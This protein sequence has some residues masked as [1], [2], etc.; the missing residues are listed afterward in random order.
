MIENISQRLVLLFTFF[1]AVVGV[2]AP[3]GITVLVVLA[4]LAGLL[5]WWRGR[6]PA[7][8]PGRP[9]LVTLGALALWALAASLWSFH[10]TG[11]MALVLRLAAVTAAGIGLM[12]ALAGLDGRTRR[13]VENAFLF[14]LALA[15]AAIAFG[16][17]YAKDTGLSLWSNFKSDPLTTLNN[18]AVTLSLLCWPAFALFRRKVSWTFAVVIVAAILAGFTALSS[19]AALL[20]PVAGCFGFVIIWFLG[21]PGAVFISIVTAIMILA[22]PQVISATRSLDMVS[23]AAESLVS[24][25]DH[26]LKMWAFAVEKIDEKRFFGWGMDS[27]R[28]IPQ[29]DRRLGPETEIMPLHPHNAFLQVRLELGIPGAVL[30][31]AL[32]GMFF[33]AAGKIENRFSSAVAVGAGMSYLSVAA[34]SYGVWQNW[35]WAFAWALAA[36]TMLALKPSSS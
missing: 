17:L 23:K 6:F 19:G 2:V 27:S 12:Y 16:A 13:M 30:V 9:L 24:S 8:F 28:G 3:K 5:R 1:L 35:W 20:A 10:P 22:A 14:G 34:V 26:R 29:E 33:A 15:L 32:V 31:A 11:G 21:R 25:T 36:M 18:G 4:G 7:I